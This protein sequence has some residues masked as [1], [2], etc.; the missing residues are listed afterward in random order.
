M[1]WVH[2]VRLAKVNYLN[3][4]YFGVFYCNKVIMKHVTIFIVDIATYLLASLL[5]YI[6]LVLFSAATK[7]LTELTGYLNPVLDSSKNQ[8]FL[9]V[10]QSHI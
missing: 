1:H 4:Q 5:I 3:L 2:W 8:E 10:S 9:Q 6:L 7:L